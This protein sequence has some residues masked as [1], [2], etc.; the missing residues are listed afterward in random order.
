MNPS[1][2]LN[3]S[4]L[5]VIDLYFDERILLLSK[6]LT[7]SVKIRSLVL[8][9]FYETNCY[10]SFQEI[11]LLSIWINSIGTCICNKYCNKDDFYEINISEY[12]TE[13]FHLNCQIAGG[14]L[15]IRRAVK[16]LLYAIRTLFI[17][18]LA[19]RVLKMRR[20]FKRDGET[21]TSRVYRGKKT[22]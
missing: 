20:L 10:T 3:D 7:L 17:V 16:R 19:S 21:I 18:H 2:F 22:L 9:C 13:C 6:E 12:E 15:I 1:I 11:S 14:F 5:N 8:L 4:I